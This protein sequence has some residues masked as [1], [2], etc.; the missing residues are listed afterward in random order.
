M[1]RSILIVLALATTTLAGPRYRLEVGH[2]LHYRTEYVAKYRFL[3]VF[4]ETIRRA[5]DRRIWVARKN[6][7]GSFRL[8]VHTRTEEDS[9]VWESFTYC[10]L[11]PDGRFVRAAP[12]GEEFHSTELFVPLPDRRD[13]TTWQALN[14]SDETLRCKSLPGKLEWPIQVAY[15]SARDQI[16]GKTRRMVV[17]IDR[18]RGLPVRVDWRRTHASEASTI[19]TFTTRLVSVVRRSAAWTAQLARESDAWFALMTN[20]ERLCAQRDEAT[21]RA[22]YAKARALARKRAGLFALPLFKSEFDALL[23]ALDDEEREA[24]TWARRSER[25]LGKPAPAWRLQGVD[26]KAHALEAFKGQ[27][28]VLDFWHDECGPCL[29]AMPSMKRLAAHFKDAPVAILGVSVDRD[30]A[31]ARKVAEAYRL[32][33]L[34]LHGRTI[35]GAY[36]VLGYPTMVVIDP[37]GIVRF[38]L[39]GH[40]PRRESELQRIIAALIPKQK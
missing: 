26:N 40:G 30:P 10:D 5:H 28:V 31:E 16:A 14:A 24:V 12:P 38:V 4:K 17:T 6:K 27:V 21:V 3:R 36:G 25:W 15:T 1:C 34:T 22:G 23:Q 19:S 7:D 33:Y 9:D 11:H 13:A 37:K 8:V 29:Q 39:I 20:S 2:E 35:S 32:N 18:K